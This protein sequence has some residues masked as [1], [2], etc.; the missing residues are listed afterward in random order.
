MINKL[1]MINS[2]KIILEKWRKLFSKNLWNS[3][4]HYTCILI[5]PDKI[6][7][8]FFIIDFWSWT[9]APQISIVNHP[10]DVCDWTGN[11]LSILLISW[12]NVYLICPHYLFV[13]LS[14]YLFSEFFLNFHNVF[15]VSLNFILIDVR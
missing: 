15:S 11:F 8:L 7:Y 4:A 1:A 14:C 9:I 12:C 5:I 6:Q 13:F 3:G 2:C 10:V